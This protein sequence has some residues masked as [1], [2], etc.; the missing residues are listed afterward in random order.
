MEITTTKPKN[1]E[2]L[3]QHFYQHGW[4]V[5]QLPN[6]EPVYITRNALLEELRRLTRN[7]TITLEQY[8]TVIEDDDQHTELQF[9]LSQFFWEQQLGKKI[10]TAQIDF[11]KALLGPDLNVQSKPHLRITRPN[12]PQDNVG[13]HRDTF[14]GNSPFELSVLIPYVNVPLES[15]ISMLSG[16]HIRPE[17]DFPITQI[18]SPD[19]TKG[20]IKNQLGFLYAPKL[21]DPIYT[22]GMEPIALNLGEAL[23]FSLSILHGAVENRGS[24]SRWS[25]DIRVVNALAPLNESLKPGYYE[26]ISRSVVTEAAHAY[27]LANQL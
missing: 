16:S 1:F 13:Y 4:M 22:V 24:I 23:I 19:I 12:K 26:Q 15:S 3:E 2:Q 10:I 21:I 17:S 7:S 20:S 11:F 5:L 14:Y 8:Q 25:S 27:Q 18:V 9:Q 6:P